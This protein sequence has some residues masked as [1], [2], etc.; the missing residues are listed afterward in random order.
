MNKNRY[1]ADW[2]QRAQRIKERDNW[3]CRHCGARHGQ[4][5]AHD[6]LGH[7]HTEEALRQMD[8]QVI[9]LIF[10]NEIEAPGSNMFDEQSDGP[11]WEK[12]RLKKSVATVAHLDHDET[13]WNVPDDR[14]ATL[15]DSCHL[16]YDATDNAR[17]RKFGKQYRD[18]HQLK[19]NL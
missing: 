19:M 10:G 6:D 8:D 15:C 11:L 9:I 16:R 3:T 17:R 18:N 7:W 5:G 4:L 1:P 13:N 14:L 2:D 12:V